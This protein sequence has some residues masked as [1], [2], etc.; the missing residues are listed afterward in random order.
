MQV[1]KKESFETLAASNKIYIK[2]SNCRHTAGRGCHESRYMSTAQQHTHIYIYKFIMK[3]YRI[4]NSR[5]NSKLIITVV[6]REPNN[7]SVHSEPAH[8]SG[9]CRMD[10]AWTG[11]AFHCMLVP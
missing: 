11:S 2:C 7:R 4:R 10:D 5:L 1:F 6:Q 9:S 8:T 3:I